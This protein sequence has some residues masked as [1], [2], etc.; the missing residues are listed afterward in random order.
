ME[1]PNCFTDNPKTNQFCPACGQKLEIHEKPSIK[2]SDFKGERKNATIL[3]SDLAGYTAMTEKMDPE[4]VKNLMGDIFEKA[5]KIVEKYGGTVEQFFGDE[6]MIL[7]GVPK[8]HEDDPVRA[9]HTAIEIHKLVE[10]LSKEFEKKYQNQLTMHTGINSGLV[11]TGDQYI[12]K[13]R[14]G[15]TGDTINLAKRLTNLAKPGEIIIGSDTY[16]TAQTSFDFEPR[17]PVAVKGKKNLVQTFKVIDTPG[18]YKSGK[19]KRTKQLHGV[20]AELIGRNRELSKFSKAVTDL[21]NGKGSALC[22]YG[23]AGTGKSRLIE[24][25]KAI[26]NV[27]W[28]EGCSYPYTKNIPYFPLLTLFDH[29][30][31]IKDEDSSKTIKTKIENSINTLIKDSKDII[32]YIGTLYS[33]SYPEVESVSPEF[34]KSKLFNAVI[35]ILSALARKQPVIICIEDLHWADPSFLEFIDF[36]QS[37]LDLP[38]LFIYV[39]R[40]IIEIFSDSQKARIKTKYLEIKIE[41]LSALDSQ[42]MVKSLLKSENIPPDLKTFVETKTQGNPFY[43]EEMINSLIES[44]VLVKDENNWIL[45]REITQAD[46]SSSIQGVIAARVD[47]LESQSRRILQEAAVIGRTFYYEII[48]KIT[49][50]KKDI[51]TCLKTLE[52]FDLIKAGKSKTDLE[53]MFKHA[54]TQ[55]VVY[56]GLLKA[57][58]RVIHEKTGQVIEQVFKERLS[59]FYE[60][61]ALHFSKGISTLKAVDYLAKSGDKS[62]K[63]YSV[64]ESHNY[65]QKAFDLIMAIEDKNAETDGKVIDILNRW[66]LVFYYKGTFRD[67]EELLFANEHLISNINDKEKI[68]MFYAWQGFVL[69][70]RGQYRKAREY[71]EKALE[72]GQEIKSKKIIGYACTWLSWLYGDLGLFK[73]GIEYGHKANEIGKEFKDDHYIYFKSLG[74]IGWNCYWMGHASQGIK[75]GDKLILYGD[76]YSLT[77]SLAMGYFNQSGGYNNFGDFARGVESSK[78][79]VAVSV[80]P[81]YKTAFTLMLSLSYLFKGDTEKAGKHLEKIMPTFEKDGAKFFREVGTLQKGVLLID[82]GFMSQGLKTLKNLEQVL[83]SQDRKGLL[84]IFRLVM[85]KIY[86]EIILKTKPIGFAT[87]IKNLGFIIKNVPTA[88]KKAIQWYTKAIDISKE[89]G[90]TGIKAQAHL[91]LGLLHKVKNRK[92]KAKE[93]LEKAIDIFEKIGAYAFLKQANRELNHLIN[94][95]S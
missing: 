50:I 78:K 43:L 69:E 35:E 13:G 74:G 93:H 27:K 68:G 15:L 28:F 40:P 8:A 44:Q 16:K 5:G 12:G 26:T 11:I 65:F 1:C 84:P 80:D 56:N 3:F 20:R 89:T 36:M 86:L 87:M 88:D 10:I 79:A 92:E 73:K 76:K 48:N 29:A 39:A 47:R 51:S 52:G 42:Y 33:L 70:F 41:D 2:V 57:D 17:D 62:I 60:T 90:A 61:L 55:E 19:L 45:Q 23:F 24:E 7:F 22:L 66:A 58:R 67:L 59:E 6:I 49:Q 53:Y 77:R 25:F 4:D 94:K 75:I 30:F 31:G 9:V 81:L 14:H 21:K 82:K 54:L 91:D 95:A 72:T 32:P 64:D 85:G 71:L 63:R 83:I 46:I 37:K 34:W 18:K 38:I